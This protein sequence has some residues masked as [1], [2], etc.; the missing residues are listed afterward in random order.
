L[1][2][3]C[4]SL[5]GVVPD[6]RKGV[7]VIGVEE[8]NDRHVPFIVSLHN[9]PLSDGQG[10]AFDV[11][12][13]VCGTHPLAVLLLLAFTTGGQNGMGC[14]VFKNDFEVVKPVATAVGVHDIGIPIGPGLDREDQVVAERLVRFVVQGK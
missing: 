8:R 6:G 3:P 7:S 1:P 11:F 12:R 14:R 5:G 10:K 13:P 9:E 4:R 2:I